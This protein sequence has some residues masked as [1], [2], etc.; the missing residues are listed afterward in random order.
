MFANADRLL[1]ARSSLN[2]PE[3]PRDPPLGRVEGQVTIKASVRALTHHTCHASGALVWRGGGVLMVCCGL[4]WCAQNGKSVT[5]PAEDVL[6]GL[7]KEAQALREEL[8]RAKIS[9]EA[10]RQGVRAWVDWSAGEVLG[11]L[12]GS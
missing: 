2:T 3:P 10:A 4:V 9:R 12:R 5:V 1:S 8:A 6:G 11:R 7:A